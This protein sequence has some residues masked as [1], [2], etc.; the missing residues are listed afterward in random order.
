VN[1]EHLEL[2]IETLP[3]VYLVVCIEGMACSQENLEGYLKESD[4]RSFFLI[5]N[6]SSAINVTVPNSTDSS[7]NVTSRSVVNTIRPSPRT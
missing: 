5:Q 3:W 7:P 4:L 2:I 1:Q 6:K